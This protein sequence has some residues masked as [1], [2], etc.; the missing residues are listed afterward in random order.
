[1][2]ENFKMGAIFSYILSL[3]FIIIGFYKMFAYYKPESFL[4]KPVNCYVGGD[5]YNFIIN[6]NYSTA[7]FTLALFCGLIGSTL[8]ICGYLSGKVE[9]AKQADITELDKEVGV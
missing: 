1:M 3:I 4:E 7:F 5:S 2:N 8:L 6:A 9:P